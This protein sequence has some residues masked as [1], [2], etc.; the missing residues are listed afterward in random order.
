MHYNY[1]SPLRQCLLKFFKKKVVGVDFFNLGAASFSL[2]YGVKNA[3]TGP[4][5]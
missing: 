3:R 1:F 5:N 4:G 2:D